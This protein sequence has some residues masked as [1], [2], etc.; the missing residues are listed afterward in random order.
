[1]VSKTKKSIKA[2][3][4]NTMKEDKSRKLNLLPSTSHEFNE[5]SSSTGLELFVHDVPRNRK[6]SQDV[7]S[8]VV[9]LLMTVNGFKRIGL[10]QMKGPCSDLKLSS[11]PR[12]WTEDYTVRYMYQGQLFILKRK[13]NES[14]IVF[15]L[16]RVDDGKNSFVELKYKLMG[17]RCGNLPEMIPANK[18]IGRK[19]ME[20][21][22]EPFI[23]TSY[24]GLVIG[25]WED[26]PYW[27]IWG[28]QILFSYCKEEFHSSKKNLDSSVFY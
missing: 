6:T 8:G 1:M 18:I 27:L 23:G 22:L 9:H 13:P 24:Q 4:S 17:L 25:F 21:L 26:Y 7:L 16:I 2:H 19:I 5:M 15:Y 3:S 28:V 14:G 12:C 10:R 20:K 11:L